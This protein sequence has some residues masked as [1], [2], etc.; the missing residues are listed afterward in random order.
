[1][2]FK[3]NNFNKH[4]F[5]LLDVLLNCM[6][7]SEEE[8]ITFELERDD[9]NQPD[10]EKDI[11]PRFHKSSKGNLEGDDGDDSEDEDDGDDDDDDEQSGNWNLRKSAASGLDIL[12]SVYRD[13][14][15]PPFLEKITPRLA[16]A[17]PWPIKEAAILALG[18]VAEGSRKSLEYLILKL[19]AFFR[20]L[21]LWHATTPATVDTLPDRT[22]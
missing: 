15:L 11:R 18:A 3:G 4:R 21:L 7:Y 20:R 9:A 14:L 1:M 2:T 13:E 10:Q 5:R 12:S 22:T 8:I 6:R 19:T 17:N 16:E